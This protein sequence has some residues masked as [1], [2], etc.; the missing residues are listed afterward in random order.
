[1]T[2]NKALFAWFNAFMPF[3]RASS[4]PKDVLFPYGTYEYVAGAWEDGDVSMTV[5]LWFYTE[6]ESI[7]DEKAQ[8]LS[9]RIGPGGVLIPCDEGFIWLRRGTPWCQSVVYED[10]LSIKRRYINITARYLTVT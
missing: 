3:Y 8:A 6:S 10:D 9:D 1:M 7:P 4:V 5:N 2:Q